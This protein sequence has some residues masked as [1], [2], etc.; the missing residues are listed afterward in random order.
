L[1]MDSDSVDTSHAVERVLDICGCVSLSSDDESRLAEFLLALW[2]NAFKAGQ[3]DGMGIVL[4]KL[5][6]C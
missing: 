4:S 2:H 3:D 6:H 5:G 1:L